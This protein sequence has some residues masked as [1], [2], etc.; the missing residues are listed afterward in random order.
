[1]VDYK[2]FYPILDELGGPVLIVL[3]SLLLYF[4]Y[5]R[6]LRIWVVNL[7]SH[8]IRNFGVAIPALAILRLFLIPAEV[9]ASFWVTQNEFGILYLFPLPNWMRYILAFLL[10]DYLLYIWHWLNH[11]IPFLWRFHN[12]HHTD[13]DLGVTTALRFHF[14]EI[15]LSSFFRIAGIIL[16]GAGPVIVLIYEVLFQS[17]VAFHHSNLKLPFKLEKIINYIIVT[18]RMH[19]IHHSMVQRETDSNYS[20]FLTIWDRLHRTLRLNIPQDDIVVG[21]PGYS[22]DGYDHTVKGLLSL[23]FRKQK[24]YWKLPN[25]T[26]PERPAQK[27][28]PFRLKP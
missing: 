1:M 28:N 6:P 5:K 12:V 9:A 7:K 18:P 22:S 3:F 14:G 21:I 19:G 2:I 17:S 15:F 27:D 4:E 11:K 8:I 24:E 23:P 16:I 13:L 26:T 20:S 10:L 25:G